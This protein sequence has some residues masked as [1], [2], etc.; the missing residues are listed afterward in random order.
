M[1]AQSFSVI[2]HHNNHCSLIPSLFLEVSK[3][4]TQRRIRVSNFSVVEPVLVNFGIRRRRLVRIVRI[5]E[6][7]PNEVS[8]GC[9]RVEPRFCVLLYFHTTA[10]D[11]SP[12]GLSRRELW[13]VIVELETAIEAGCEILAVEDH[14]AYKCRSAVAP[15]REQF[16]QGGINSCQRDTEVADSER[17]L[18]EP[19]HATRVR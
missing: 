1:F 16:C 5:V 19:S 8:T 13:E 3:E 14:R 17:A 10:L 4:V 15:L 12:P 11:A 2:S 6:V 9:V 18:Q 7:H